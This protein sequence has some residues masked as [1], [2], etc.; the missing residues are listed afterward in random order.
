MLSPILKAVMSKGE[1]S[2]YLHANVDNDLYAAGLKLARNVFVLR[3]GGVVRSPGSLYVGE[4]KDSADFTRMLSFAFNREQVYVIEAGP[5]YFRFWTADG[6]VESGGSPVEVTTPYL[7]DDLGNIKFRQNADVVYIFCKGYQPRT[8]TRNSETSWTLAEYTPK[9][10]PYMEENESGTVLTPSGNGSYTPTMTSASAPSGTVTG[11]NAYAYRMFDGDYGGSV[12]I[13]GSGEGYVQY[14]RTAAAAIDGYCISAND[15]KSSTNPKKWTIYGSNDGAT[16]RIVDARHNESGWG[17]GE[18]RYFSF[19][20]SAQ[21]SYL[22]FSWSGGGSSEDDATHMRQLRYHIHPDDQTAFDLTASAVT[23]INDGTGFQ[24]TDVGRPIK[25]MDADGRWR[26]L[27]IISVTSTTV[28]TVKVHDFALSSLRGTVRWALGA[29]SEESGWPARVAFVEDRLVGARTDAD[30]LGVWASRSGDYDHH[31]VSDPI[32]DDDAISLRLTG[33][34][35]NDISWLFEGQTLIAGTSSSVRTIS[36]ADATKALA[37]ANVIQR[38]DIQLATGDEE[39]VGIANAFIYLDYYNQRLFETVYSYET[40]SLQAMELTTLCEHLFA[41]GVSK[42]VYLSHPVRTLVGL[43]YDG[44]L[45]AFAYDREQKVIGGTLLDFGGEVE[46]ILEL[47]GA[48]GSD[49]W[50]IVKRTIDGATVRYIERLAEFYRTDFAV[51]VAPVYASCSFIYDGAPT[52]QITGVDPLEGETVGV[53]ADGRDI[54]D[55]TVTGGVVD[56]NEHSLLGGDTY[57]TVVVGLR[58]PMTGRTLR[59]GTLSRNGQTVSIGDQKHVG[60]IG[61]DVYDTGE[62]NVG[63]PSK[64]DPLTADGDEELDPGQPYPLREGMFRVPVDDSWLNTGE[65]V[66]ETDKMY[67][68]TVRAVV[69]L[70]EE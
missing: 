12:F 8:L 3:Y 40:N 48:V 69:L 51:Q 54:G 27:E 7:V 38:A 21:F 22:K 1:I 29:W 47:P 15:K 44:K 23:G 52:S 24:S 70:A 13:S 46:D 35:L 61:I 28:V 58:M 14:Q 64:T 39:P 19:P 17:G 30:P 11:T 60:G 16:W 66:F 45:V 56:L 9:D 26:W 33:G 10:G 4:V 63:S 25:F 42:I 62:L 55:F 2:P 53:W 41:I 32:V 18:N 5:E 6:R 37:P 68:V 50:M 49:L 31:G 67:P 57:S 59:L 34:Q 20:K 65:I 36:R 43:R